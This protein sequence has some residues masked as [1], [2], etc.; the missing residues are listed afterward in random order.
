[1]L[2][3]QGFKTKGVHLHLLNGLLKRNDFT[4]CFLDI[5]I[6]HFGVYLVILGGLHQLF[7]LTFQR[8]MFVLK[9]VVIKIPQLRGEPCGK[10]DDDC[11]LISILLRHL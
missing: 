4:F 1:M 10:A 11:L 8:R 5:V 7:V 9:F 6:Q 3:V 2:Q